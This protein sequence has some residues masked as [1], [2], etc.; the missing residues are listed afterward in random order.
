VNQLLVIFVCLTAGILLKSALPSLARFSAQLNFAVINICLPALALL[1][2]PE[3]QFNADLWMPVSVAWIVFLLAWVFFGLLRW[4]LRFDLSTMGSMLLCCGLCNT[5]FIGFPTI[6]ALYGKE[7]LSIAIMTDQV[8]SFLVLSTLGVF[9]ASFF[10]SGKANVFPVLKKVF[11]FLPFLTFLAAIGLR[12]LDVKFPSPTIQVLSFLAT[13]LT[14]L[15]L[16]SVGL[17]LNLAFDKNFINH[18]AWGLTFKLIIAPL[19]IFIFFYAM[20]GKISLVLTVSVLQAAMAPMISGCILAVNHRLH[21]Q[22]SVAFVG[23]GI[24][25][26]FITISI[27]YW[28]LEFVF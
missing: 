4:W 17:Q 21:P 13:L 1:R 26:S 2:V 23:W 18:L 25:I 11:S 14:P 15:A 28:L 9:F 5:A 24:P 16:V 7:G 10:S 19:C 22:L 12:Y 27:W 8:G 3:L 20:E 6:N